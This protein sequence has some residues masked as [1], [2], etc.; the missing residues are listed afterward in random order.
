M[1]RLI[2]LGIALLLLI[3]L[4]ACE[5]NFLNITPNGALDA[6]V[7]A[8]ETGID[9]LLI[10]VYSM[11]D[12]TSANGFGWEAA[13]SNWVF[14][15]MRAMI[16]NKGSDAGDQSDINPLQTYNETATNLFLNIKWRSL[17]ESISRANA[18]LQVVSQAEESGDITAE[19]A[20]LFR[21][22]LRALRG[23][24]H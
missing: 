1:K 12:G 17:Y 9:N 3:S 20:A 22:Q 13:A 10:G 4:H 14:G 21:Q 8:T 19:Q 18:A 24:F 23:H 2:R 6:E 5:E 11:L 15:S 16:A 7:L